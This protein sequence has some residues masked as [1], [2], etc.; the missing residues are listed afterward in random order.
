MPW[1]HGCSERRDTSVCRTAR[2][3]RW[4]CRS[5]LYSRK[6]GLRSAAT[7]SHSLRRSHPSMCFCHILCG[8]SSVYCVYASPSCAKAGLQSLPT[9]DELSQRIKQEVVTRSWPSCRLAFTNSVPRLVRFTH[10]KPWYASA[11][12]MCTAGAHN[13]LR[14]NHALQDLL[15]GP[16]TH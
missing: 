15:L 5:E 2:Q 14:A 4:R 6:Q 13:G 3:S 7:S 11:Q 16:S 12:V 10:R 1:T 8:Q 9:M